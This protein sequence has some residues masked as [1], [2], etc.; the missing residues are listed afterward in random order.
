MARASSLFMLTDWYTWATC[1]S[2]LKG[3]IINTNTTEMINLV[4]T[5]PDEGHVAQRVGVLRQLGLLALL[6]R[7]EAGVHLGAQLQRVEVHLQPVVQ[8]PHLLARR[9]HHAE[10]GKRS[11]DMQYIAIWGQNTREDFYLT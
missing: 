2:S 5:P 10:P 9:G 8:V 4:L 11:N 7:L 1:F 3:E 6:Q